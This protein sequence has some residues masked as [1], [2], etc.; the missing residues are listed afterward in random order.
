[1]AIFFSVGF[2]FIGAIVFNKHVLNKSD[3]DLKT[4][5]YNFINAK[6]GYHSYRLKRPVVLSVKTLIW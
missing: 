6:F 4:S 3:Y 2:L 5:Q 1:M